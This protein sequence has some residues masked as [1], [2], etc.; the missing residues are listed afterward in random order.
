MEANETKPKNILVVEDSDTMRFI[1][2]EYFDG[3]NDYRLDLAA[4]AKEGSQ[5]LEEKDFDLV[6]LDVMMDDVSGDTFCGYLRG[7]PRTKDLPVLFISVLE[8][9][10]LEKMKERYQAPY[11]RKPVDKDEMIK[12]IQSLF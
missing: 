4:S 8:E 2:Q 6:I 7:L 12:K 9:K 5:R 11:L 10:V 3:E 1:Y